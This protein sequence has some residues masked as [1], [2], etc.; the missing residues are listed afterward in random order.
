MKR[1][2]RNVKRRVL[3]I[4]QQRAVFLAV[5]VLALVVLGWQL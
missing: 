5:F 4:A 2:T 1:R 3:S